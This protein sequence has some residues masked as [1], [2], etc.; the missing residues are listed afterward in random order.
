[1]SFSH[2]EIELETASHSRIGRPADRAAEARKLLSWQAA[3]WLGDL[4]G[5]APDGSP[6]PAAALPY[7][8]VACDLRPDLAETQTKLGNALLDTGEPER[9]AAAYRMALRDNPLSVD[10]ARGLVTALVGAGDLEGAT[11]FYDETLG[12]LAAVPMLLER[13]PEL[14]RA[15]WEAVTLSEA[16][17]TEGPLGLDGL[18]ARNYL[19]FAEGER[20]LAGLDAYVG[21]VRPEAD[22]CLILYGTEV[23]A[24]RLLAR[25]ESHIAAGGRAAADL[26]DILVVERRLTPR[27]EQQLIALVDGVY[28]PGDR[29]R[30]AQVQAAGKPLLAE[31]A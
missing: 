8:Q 15:Y 4:M 25:I 24:D 7:Y 6:L 26:P 17:R 20:W 10:A 3:A 9:A 14:Q 28:P 18:R 31:F 23:P 27:Q 22:A 2:L 5:V 19:L 11:V 30:L 12:C 29:T 1:M 21:G 13:L 16:S